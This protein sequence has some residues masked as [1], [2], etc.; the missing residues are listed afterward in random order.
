MAN[1]TCKEVTGSTAA[2]QDIKDDL[3][4]LLSEAKLVGAM[5]EDPTEAVDDDWLRCN[6]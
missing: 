4:T 1:E 3:K 6:Q 2:K 5:E